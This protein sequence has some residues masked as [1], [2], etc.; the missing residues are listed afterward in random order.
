MKFTIAIAAVAAI[1]PLVSAAPA[2]A[3]FNE[4]GSEELV[5]RNDWD[6]ST[7]LS[8][9][10]LSIFEGAGCKGRSVLHA[11]VG[12][13]YNYPNVAN[14]KSYRI[15]RALH[16]GERLDF[17]TTKGGKVRRNWFTDI[18]K[19][20]DHAH[21]TPVEQ[22]LIGKRAVNPLCAAYT[23]SAPA[24]QVKGCYNINVPAKCFNLHHK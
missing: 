22:Y 1:L 21:T 17:S 14:I 8:G 20:H 9:L 24:G 11:N 18:F 6:S 2:P 12:W 7:G 15:S 4:T 13:N 16:L 19:H 3:A 10:S 23:A 5:A